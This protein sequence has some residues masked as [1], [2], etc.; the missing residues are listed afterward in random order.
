MMLDLLIAVLALLVGIAGARRGASSQLAGWAAFVLAVLAA[1]PGAQL[2]GPLFASFLH[3]APGTARIAAGFC[4]FVLVLVGARLVLDFLLRGVLTLG[5]PERRGLDRT[6]GFALGALKVLAITWVALSALAF[7]E[8]RFS[9][10]GNVF[11]ISP[12]R[13][14]AFAA[15]RRWNFFGMADFGATQSLMKLEQALR[16]PGGQARLASDPAVAA[17][18]KDPRFKAVAEDPVVK[19]AVEQHDVATLL[20]TDSVRRLLADADSREKLMEA[21]SAVQTPGPA[22]GPSVRPGPA[23]TK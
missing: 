4:T 7:V 12:E 2:F 10:S 3:A 14:L 13:S 8:E 17:L 5:N 23:S 9:L 22:P 6:L 21:L 15:A 1:R 11:G 16:R 20:R 18:L 19:K